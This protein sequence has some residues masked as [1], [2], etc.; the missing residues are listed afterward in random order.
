MCIRDS[1]YKVR[2]LVSDLGIDSSHI[3]NQPSICLGAADM[4]VYEMTG[5]YSAFANNG[6]YITPSFITRIEDKNGK[7]IYKNSPDEKQALTQDY[8]FAVVELLRYAMRGAAGLNGIVSDMGGKTGTT[9]DYV[10]GWFMGITPSLAVGT[11]VG[12]DDRWIRFL[13][14]GNGQGS[15]MARPFF[16]EFIRELEKQ[17]VADYDPK[18]TVS[19]TH[20]TLPTKRIV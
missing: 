9:N 7:V 3:P 12:G 19:Y 5:A 8:N 20:L 16:T 17:K 18:K 11:W 13:S 15:K 2:G 10:D 1:P 4:T 14:I 6:T